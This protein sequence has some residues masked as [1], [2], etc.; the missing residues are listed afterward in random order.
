MEIYVMNLFELTFRTSLFHDYIL[1]KI[2]FHL[3]VRGIYRVPRGRL[4]I[5]DRLSYITDLLV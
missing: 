5:F 4:F 2:L 1:E 3:K